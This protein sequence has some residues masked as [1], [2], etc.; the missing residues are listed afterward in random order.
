LRQ[1]GC[2]GALVQ[3]VFSGSPTNPSPLAAVAHGQ[4]RSTS[5]KEQHATNEPATSID[6]SLATSPLP[7]LSL[8]FPALDG[9]TQI[10]LELSVGLNGD[11]SVSGFVGD[12]TGNGGKVLNNAQ[13]RKWA[14]GLEVCGAV[15]VW[16]EWVRVEEAQ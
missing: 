9:K 2:F 12:V 8:T 6:V 13:A 7:V 3:D 1:W 5:T 11:V 14:K 4:S 16:V 15:A 10:S